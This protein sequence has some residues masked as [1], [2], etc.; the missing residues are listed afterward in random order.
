MATKGF[1]K[2]IVKTT[3]EVEDDALLFETMGFVEGYLTAERTVQHMHNIMPSAPPEI[4]AHILQHLEYLQDQIDMF[5]ESD[6]YW[7]VVDFL[8][9]R[10]RGFAMGLRLR[11]EMNV[12]ES[13][14]TSSPPR[15][16]AAQEVRLLG[17]SH[18]MLRAELMRLNLAV[19]V[20]EIARALEFSEGG[21]ISQG[22]AAIARE[23]RAAEGTKGHCSALVKIVGPRVLFGHTSWAGFDNLLRIWKEYNFPHVKFQGLASRHMSFSSYPGF[24]ASSDDWLVMRDTQ[25]LVME[26]TIDAYDTKRLAKYVSPASVS[27]SMRSLVASMLASHA[28][29]WYEIFSREN[30]GVQ[31]NQWM[32]F[33]SREW[34]ATSAAGVRPS[35]ARDIFWV[36][37]QQPGQ[38]IARDMSA[39]LLEDGYWASWNVAY[40]K[41]TLKTNLYFEHRTQQCA[42]EGQRGPLLDVLQGQIKSLTDMKEA[43]RTNTWRSSHLSWMCPK[44][45][46][47]ARFDLPG[48]NKTNGCFSPAFFGSIDAK[49]TNDLMIIAGE[50]MFAS[51]PPN[52]GVPAFSWATAASVS[53]GARMLRHEGHPEGAMNFPWVLVGG[54][55]E[56]LNDDVIT[57]FM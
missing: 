32:I 1:G 12:P 18:T 40:F 43:F 10:Q 4:E 22:V 38:V 19:D 49:A 3:M 23:A 47:S 56:P 48:A 20:D 42:C 5:A 30:S 21:N 55:D 11:L 29:E 16:L 34:A 46:I 44:C 9:T 7:K 53:P 36:A 41:E 2:L 35:T 13:V 15:P 45:S 14:S 26:T 37:E 24:F 33:S 6:P 51:G 54:R 28:R 8:L 39:K 50:S 25:L 17:L 57:L 52:I 27:T 31:N